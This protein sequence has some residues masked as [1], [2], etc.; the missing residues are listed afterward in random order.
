MGNEIL[1]KLR[2]V[3]DYIKGVASLL[4]PFVGSASAV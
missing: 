4:E 3:G 2:P 1:V